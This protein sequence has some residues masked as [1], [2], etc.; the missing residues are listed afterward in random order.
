[1]NA[2]D[3]FL[4][5]IILLLAANLVA[6][7]WSDTDGHATDEAAAVAVAP[8]LPKIVSVELKEELLENFIEY[9]N[10][11]DFDEI[12]TMLG[13]SARA[14]VD[15]DTL[16]TRFEKL[17]KLFGSIENGAYSHSLLVGTQGATRI[18]QLYY[19]LKLSDDSELGDA[20]TLQITLEIEGEDYQIYDLSLQVGAYSKT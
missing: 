16:E 12:Y 19:Q 3:G 15:E 4:G 11:R 10:D 9:F 17:A 20:G 6:M 7:L 13:P 1:M 8:P 14:Q 2:R 5:L 18:Y